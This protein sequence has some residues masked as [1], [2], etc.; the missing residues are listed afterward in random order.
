MLIVLHLNV[1]PCI[2]KNKL[3]TTLL[4]VVIDW[5]DAEING[6]KLVVGQ[7][8]LK[9]CSVHWQRSCQR[10]ADRVTSSTNKSKEKKLFLKIAYKKSRIP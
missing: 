10:I 5:S 7:Q 4:G 2:N 9:G 3:G 8:L 1:F 6:L